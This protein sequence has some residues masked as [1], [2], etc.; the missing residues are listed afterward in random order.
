MHKVRENVVSIYK[1]VM[2]NEHFQLNF[3][4]LIKKSLIF[5]KLANVCQLY[6]NDK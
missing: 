1:A 4:C 2:Y 6:E 5:G 3:V